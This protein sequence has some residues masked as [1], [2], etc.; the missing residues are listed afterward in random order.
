MCGEIGS[1][2]TKFWNFFSQNACKA[3][4]SLEL[5]PAHLFSCR[6]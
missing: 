5:N 2:P 6:A 3:V 1:L 4:E